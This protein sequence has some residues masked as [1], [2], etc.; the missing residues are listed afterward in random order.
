MRE[1]KHHS[2]KIVS[3]FFQDVVD[4]NKRAETRFNDRDYRVGDTIT[5]NEGDLDCGDFIY[6]GRKVSGTI[7]H[8]CSYG[9]QEDWVVLSLSKI[10]MLI[11]DDE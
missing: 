11:V 10:G 8:I 7:S 6:T 9:Q 2:L 4:G 5:L 3:E 1:P